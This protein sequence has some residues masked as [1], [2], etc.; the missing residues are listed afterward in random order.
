VPRN[1]EAAELCIAADESL[2]YARHSQ[3][4]ASRYADEEGDLGDV[5]TLFS[6]TV[7]AFGRRLWRRDLGRKGARFPRLSGTRRALCCLLLGRERLTSLPDHDLLGVMSCWGQPGRVVLP[8][9]TGRKLRSQ[10]ARLSRWSAGV[11]RRGFLLWV[12]RPYA[13]RERLCEIG[14]VD[15]ERGADLDRL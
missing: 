14:V 10:H 8:S 15:F 2:A 6:P 1:V 12:P 11:R 13:S 5:Q 7:D 3:L 4:N 9:G